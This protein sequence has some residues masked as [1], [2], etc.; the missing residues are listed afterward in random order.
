MATELA[1]TTTPEQTDRLVEVRNLKMYF[2]VRRGLLFER[3][4]GHVHAVDDISF[5]V[6]R[7]E[8]LGLV[9][10]SGCGKTTVGRAVLR[11]VPAAS[12]RVVFDGVDVLGAGRAAL[13]TLR[14]RMQIVFQDPGGSLNPRM[15]VGEIVAEP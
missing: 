6:R 2:P 1:P 7:G 11:L 10:E 15:R 9:G 4:V 8:T 13:R 3:T 5:H 12:G 14:R